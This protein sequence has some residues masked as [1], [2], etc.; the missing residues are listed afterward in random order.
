MRNRGI[1]LFLPDS[2]LDDSTASAALAQPMQC[3]SAA[4]PAEEQALLALPLPSG[5][6]EAS[7]D[8]EVLLASEGVPDSALRRGMAAAHLAVVR[9]AAKFHRCDANAPLLSPLLASEFAGSYT[10]RWMTAQIW[11]PQQEA[12]KGVAISMTP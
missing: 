4:L 1:E 12:L 6:L 3:P 9:T 2:S 7:S 5:A 8:L 10:Q 11:L